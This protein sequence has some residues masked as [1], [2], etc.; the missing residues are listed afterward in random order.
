AKSGVSLMV[1]KTAGRIDRE[2]FFCTQI[3]ADIL[4]HFQPSHESIK[5]AVEWLT[6]TRQPPHLLDGEIE[7]T[8][9]I[10]AW[11]I[12]SAILPL[13]YEKNSLMHVYVSLGAVNY[14]TVGVSEL[15]A[16]IQSQRSLDRRLLV[17]M[18]HCLAPH[19]DL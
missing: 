3:L 1:K 17:E 8:P 4:Q 16:W 6:S 7:K 13:I 5:R 15:R 10:D 12:S 19:G 9:A 18:P 11:N 2:K 14:A